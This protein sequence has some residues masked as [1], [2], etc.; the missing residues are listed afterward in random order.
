MIDPWAR[1]DSQYL[2]D[3]HRIRDYSPWRNLS[4]TVATPIT[5]V[6]IPPLSQRAEATRTYSA[7]GPGGLRGEVE[8]DQ[9][10]AARSRRAVRAAAPARGRRWRRFA[11]G[12]CASSRVSADARCLAVESGP[13]SRTPD[14][15]GVGSR[16][17]SPTI[18]PRTSACRT[19][20]T[21]QIAK[22]RKGFAPEPRGERPRAQARQGHPGPA[23]RR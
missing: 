3:V 6:C 11:L 20:I 17:T 2:V 8:I 1:Q 18:G 14:A 4:V 21:L 22:P 16:V 13:S 19:E 23:R 7:P 12:G 10:N 15:A 9:D 5:R